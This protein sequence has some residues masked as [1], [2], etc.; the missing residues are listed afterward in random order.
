MN[1]QDRVHEEVA[2]KISMYN[3]KEDAAY[4][5]YEFED[6]SVKNYDKQDV[7]NIE[8]KKYEGIENG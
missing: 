6:T 8:H 1:Y 5:G 3:N 2:K 4:G 7:R